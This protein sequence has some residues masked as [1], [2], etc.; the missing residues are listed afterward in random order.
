MNKKQGIIIVTLLALI[1]C[2]GILATKTNSTPYVS[3]D[4]SGLG[5]SAFSLKSNDT[6]KKTASTDFFTQARL[7]KVQ[8]STKA[9]QDLKTVMDNKNIAEVDRKNAANKYTV[10]S[11]AGYY[12]NKIETAL[13]SS[14]FEDVICQVEEDGVRVI[15][16]SKDKLTD[17]QTKEIKNTVLSISKSNQV[18]IQT[19]Y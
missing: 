3:E 19:Q 15:V 6:S 1:V 7:S 12:E 11:T 4:D 10:I 17:K 9:L 13:K 18:T 8:E 16:K 14:G 5:K 2:V